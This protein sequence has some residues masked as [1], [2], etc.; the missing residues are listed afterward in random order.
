M[1]RAALTALLLLT[2]CGGAPAAT[3]EAA[4][5][6]LA[7]Y[8]PFDVSEVVLRGAGGQAVD[9]PVYVADTQAER[10]RGLMF[11]Q[12]LR[13][14]AGMVF[15]FPDLHTGAFYMKNTLI[16]L[17]IAFYGPDGRVRRVL[18]MQPCEADP[19]ELYDPGVEYVGALEVNQGFFDQIG[20][21]EAWTVELPDD[22]PEASS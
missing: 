1:I 13:A 2:A 8:G 4:P 10:A 15:T 9:V 7:P 21:D 18:D 6:A 11:R 14:D 17:S 12:D 20:L 3:T 5:D 22:L 19:C 16:P